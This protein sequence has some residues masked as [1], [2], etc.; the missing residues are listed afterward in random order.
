MHVKMGNLLLPSCVACMNLVR[1]FSSFQ[2]YIMTCF[3]A[4]S[5]AVMKLECE[6]ISSAL[7]CVEQLIL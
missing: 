4:D 2:Y 3:C 6:T 7:C 1:F 5:N